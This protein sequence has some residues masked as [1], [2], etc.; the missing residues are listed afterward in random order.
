MHRCTTHA[1]ATHERASTPAAEHGRELA[2]G[3]PSTSAH[4][5]ATCPPHPTLTEAGAEVFTDP[6]LEM[7]EEEKKA[8]AAELKRAAAEAGAAA[9]GGD[10]DA[11]VGGP[12]GLGAGGVSAGCGRRL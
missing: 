6:F 9:A 11:Q 7:E 12:G 8:K 5:P 2:P 1:H 10:P 4:P 3:H